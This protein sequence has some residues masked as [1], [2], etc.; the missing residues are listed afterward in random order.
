MSIE[1]IHQAARN[2]AKEYALMYKP[3][4]LFVVL[5]NGPNSMPKLY[6]QRTIGGFIILKYEV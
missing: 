3:G 6:A 4:R 1:Q 2:N 5:K